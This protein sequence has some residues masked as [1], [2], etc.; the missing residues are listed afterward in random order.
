MLTENATSY[1]LMPEPYRM[2]R[3]IQ[4]VL[5][6]LEP[7][8]LN[9]TKSRMIQSLT[10]TLIRGAKSA[11]VPQTKADPMLAPVRAKSLTR[12]KPNDCGSVS[13]LNVA[14]LW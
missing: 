6:D 5:A 4:G 2:P 7:R 3:K 9:G 14:C 11:I 1:Q 12:A 13:M 8:V 10:K